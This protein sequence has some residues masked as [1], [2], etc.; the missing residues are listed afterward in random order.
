MRNKIPCA[1]MRNRFFKLPRPKFLNS[2]TNWNSLKFIILNPLYEIIK[3]ILILSERQLFLNIV[4]TDIRIVNLFQNDHF[5]LLVLL[6]LNS[7]SKNNQKQL[8][9]AF[10]D[11]HCLNS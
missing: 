2:L 3:K 9:M 11:A 5:V 1:D 7:G 8:S 4:L 6:S 10:V